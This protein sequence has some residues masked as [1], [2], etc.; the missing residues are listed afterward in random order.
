[1]RVQMIRRPAYV[2]ALASTLALGGC[3]DDWLTTEPQTILT[4]EQLYGDPQLIVNLLADYYDRLPL[5]QGPQG[6]GETGTWINWE[7]ADEGIISR[8]N[9]GQVN[10]SGVGS[11]AN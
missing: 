11:P 7:S 10:A 9:T 6:V 1:M 8:Q 3:L 5:T 2:L 4:D